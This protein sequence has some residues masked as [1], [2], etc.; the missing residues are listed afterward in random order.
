[1]CNS[2]WLVCDRGIGR[3]VVERNFTYSRS[4]AINN[5]TFASQREHFCNCT[6][7]IEF[8]GAAA[9]AITPSTK[10]KS[11]QQVR[12][13]NLPKIIARVMHTLGVRRSDTSQCWAQAIHQCTK[14]N[15]RKFVEKSVQQQKK[16]VRGKNNRCADPNEFNGFPAERRHF[17]AIF[18][19]RPE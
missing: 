2:I 10:G 3:P 8:G 6:S 13:L 17:D 4:C 5:W 15:Q 19:V 1:M 9:A 7:E 14:I 11:T 16:N 18:V 12:T